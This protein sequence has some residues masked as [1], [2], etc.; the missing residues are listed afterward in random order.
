MKSAPDD[1]IRARGYAFRLLSYRERSVKEMADRLAR[2][3]FSD[4]VR[5]KVVSDLKKHGLI[6]DR[7]FA[8]NFANSRLTHRPSGLPMIISELSSKG[9]GRDIIDL[10]ME[11]ISKDYDEYETACRIAAVR[12]G[13]YRN[14]DSLKAKRR[15]YG[16]LLRRRFRKDVIYRVLARFFNE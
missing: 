1:L 10:V 13:K 14:I 7:R 2:K 11:E 9:I 15:L 4:R 3:G 12:V 5:A 6:D 8:V 16:H